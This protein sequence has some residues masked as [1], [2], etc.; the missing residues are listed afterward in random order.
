MK[1]KGI[2]LFIIL[3][4]IAPLVLAQ[5]RGRTFSPIG[6]I[7]GRVIDDVTEKG[8][9]YANVVVYSL[10]DSTLID[11]A[12]SDE[13]GYYYIRNIPLGHYYISAKFIGFHEALSEDFMVTPGNLSIKVNDIRLKRAALQ[14]SEIQVVGE[15]PLVEFKADK[16]VVHA[17]QFA[18]SLSGTAVEIL[19]NVPS[20]DVDADGTVSLRGSSNFIVMIDGHPSIFDGSD[21]LEQIPATL[22]QS[23]EIITNPSA[24]YDPDGTTGIINVITKKQKISG[25]SSQV[26]VNAG[27]NESYGTSVA[28]SMR[29]DKLTWNNSLSWND[30]QFENK[31]MS[32]KTTTINDT[33]FSIYGGGNGINKN[34]RY[35]YRTSLDWRATDNFLISAQFN[36]GHNDRSGQNNQTFEEYPYYIFYTSLDEDTQKRDNWGTGLEFTKKFKG[37]NHDLSGSVR[38][39]SRLNDEFS[40]TTRRTVNENITDRTKDTESSDDK[41]WRI[42]LDYKNMLTETHG[43]EAGL[44]SRI[45]FDEEEIDR[46]GWDTTA[47]EYIY[48]PQ[49][50]HS[51]DYEHIIHSLYAIYKNE[52]GP[53]QGQ[54][55]VRGEYTYRNMQLNTQD[56]T[57]TLDRW[58]IFPSLH[59]SL[60]IT[61]NNQLMASYTRRINRP[62]NWFLEPYRTQRDAYSVFQGNPSL[63]PEYIDAWEASWQV[64]Q[65]RNYL[66]ADIYHRETENK[67]EQVQSVL[68]KETMLYTFANVGKDYSTGFELSLNVRPLSFWNIFLSGTVYRYRIEGN[69]EERTF[70]RSSNNW[71]TKINNTFFIGDNA[72]LEFNTFYHGPSVTSQGR[73]ESFWRSNAAVKYD[74]GES[75]TAAIQLRD[76]FGDNTHEFTSSGPNFV[77]TTKSERESPIA[78]ITLTYRFNN[79]KNGNKFRE[80]NDDMMNDDEEELFMF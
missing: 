64:S 33:V 55:G 4:A 40:E 30:A 14:M 31:R 29:F 76:I 12:M 8:I 78:F 68:D 28:F 56:T 66:A 53:F 48:Y 15:R 7:Q 44:Q 9:S 79:Y 38:Y 46:Y 25:I 77:N 16:R 41:N 67:I 26:S 23:I 54:L 11:G 63:K 32:N 75:F 37:K 18:T 73:R 20:I 27:S 17:D 60:P 80:D 49:Y 62:R 6:V 1:K 13:N 24:R 57:Y 36:I 45:S 5:D 71:G 21:A 72:R 65:K 69:F 35:S 51:N 34:T 70:D 61:E 19:E 22:V 50:S 10:P 43:I 39:T 74:F 58:D 52:L 3:L 2:K 59:V 42:K 47:S